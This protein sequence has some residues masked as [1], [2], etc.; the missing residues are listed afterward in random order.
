MNPRDAVIVSAVRTPIANFN[1]ALKDVSAVRL[2]S[3]VIQ[4]AL[5]QAAIGPA[6]VDEVLMGNVLQAGLGQN[7]A[8][9]ALLAAGLP[10]EIPAAT[11]NKV[12]GSGLK[13]VHLAWQSIVCGE[14]DIAVAGGMENM[15]QAPYLLPGARGGYRMGDRSAVDSMIRDGLWCASGDYHMGV[16]A[17]HLW[18]PVCAHPGA[19]R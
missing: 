10:Q 15:S 17:E 7:P 19:A 11:I 4:A 5:K 1:G 18:R 8:R 16:T 2:G 6:Q 13:A 9:Q 12:C 3:V 14:S